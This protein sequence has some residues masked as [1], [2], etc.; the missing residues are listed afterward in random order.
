MARWLS[1]KGI[2]V[3]F[4]V[5][6][7]VQLSYGQEV[8]I[9]FQREEDSSIYAIN[10]DGSNLMVMTE[11]QDPVR[12]PDGQFILVNRQGAMVSLSSDGTASL[13]LGKGSWP[14]WGSMPSKTPKGTTAPG[15]LIQEQ[16]WGEVKRDTQ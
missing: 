9:L 2:L 4:F 11:G 6:T 1:S 5:Q 14:V 12:S 10:P 3:L 13:Q 15:S 16:S 7:W 8:P